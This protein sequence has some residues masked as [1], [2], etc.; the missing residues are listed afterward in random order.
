[1]ILMAEKIEGPLGQP[2]QIL[3]PINFLLFQVLIFEGN[4]ETF[5]ELRNKNKFFGKRENGS[6]SNQHK[7]N[8]P[9]NYI[10]KNRIN[11]TKNPFSIQRIHE[12][13]YN[14]NYSNNQNNQNNQNNNSYNNNI[15]STIAQ[16]D[17]NEKSKKFNDFSEVEQQQLMFF[18][19]LEQNHIHR[20]SHYKTMKKFIDEIFKP[21]KK[22]FTTHIDY[23]YEVFVKRLKFKLSS[24]SSYRNLESFTSLEIASNPLIQL[25]LEYIQVS[26]DYRMVMT[27]Y[28]C[29]SFCYTGDIK[30]VILTGHSN[31]PFQSHT[32][33]K[34]LWVYITPTNQNAFNWVLKQ[35]TTNKNNIFSPIQ[36]L[37]NVFLDRT[38]QIR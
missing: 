21:N 36:K 14:N 35:N 2:F 6:Y 38:T 7:L 8:N 37:Y 25:L 34:E 30:I 3:I 16:P 10:A 1:M 29:G 18:M 27:S 28:V 32:C 13:K 26:N 31:V 33:S 9:F 11:N 17:T 22:Y 4:P 20:R 24:E 5:F 23:S 15:Q 12:E 19:L